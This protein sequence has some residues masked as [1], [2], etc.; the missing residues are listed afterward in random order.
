MSDMVNALEDWKGGASD[1]M[2]NN[3]VA[4]R[5]ARLPE[6]IKAVI[7]AGAAIVI[8][9]TRMPQKSKRQSK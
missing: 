8:T 1:R 9:T 7:F 2:A 6:I 5:W 4:Q 3:R